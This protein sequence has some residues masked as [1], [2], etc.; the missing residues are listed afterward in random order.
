[1]DSDKQVQI[2]QMAYAG[3]LADAVLQ[4]DKEGVLQHV[5][6]RKRLVQLATGKIMATQFGMDKP[7]EVF[8]KLSELFGCAQW[9]I[10]NSSA[11]GFVAQANSCRLCAIAKKLGAPSPCRIYC[12]NPMEGLVKALKENVAY[13]VEETLWEGERC[14]VRVGKP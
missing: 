3:A 1:M 4:F 6:D 9:E 10:K 14:R 12:L 8:L 5:S 13:T 2:L 7:E 11:E